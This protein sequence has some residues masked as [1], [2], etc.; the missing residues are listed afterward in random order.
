MFS[1]IRRCRCGHIASA[2]SQTTRQGILMRLGCDV[3]G[4]DCTLFGARPIIPENTS[5]RNHHSHYV[6]VVPVKCPNCGPMGCI[7]DKEKPA[8]KDHYCF[9]CNEVVMI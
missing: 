8:K 2:H 6:R 7:T 9:G 5:R 1:R 3:D 4:C